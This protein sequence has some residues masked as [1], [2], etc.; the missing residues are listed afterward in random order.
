MPKK[1]EIVV[2]GRFAEI[3]TLC[4]FIIKGAAAAGMDETALF[5]IELA[6]DEACTNI[7]EHAYG[8]EDIGTIYASWHVQDEQF[9]ITLHDHGRPFNPADV[10][11]PPTEHTPGKIKVGGLGIHFMRQLMDSVTYHFDDDHGNTLIMTKKLPG[12]SL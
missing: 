10:P 4:Q 7:I 1:Q 5:H 12:K 6:C 2:P 3:K 11:T 9:V 8:S